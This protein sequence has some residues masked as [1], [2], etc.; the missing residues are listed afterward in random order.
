MVMAPMRCPSTLTPAQATPIHFLKTQFQPQL[1]VR[2]NF[3]SMLFC[4]HDMPAIVAFQVNR[5]QAARH[6][7]LAARSRAWP[8]RHLQSWSAADV[9]QF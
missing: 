4:R 2:T 3:Q 8:R 6:H 9:S 1:F 5:P 7:N